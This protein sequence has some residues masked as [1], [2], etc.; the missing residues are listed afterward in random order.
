MASSTHRIRI[1]ANRNTVFQALSTETGLKGW[2]TANLDG[3]VAQGETATFHFPK[4]ETFRWKFTEVKPDSKIIW[5]C[6][7]GPGAAKGT[8][9]VFQLSDDGGQET[10][11]TCEHM[12]WPEGH[13][14][15]ATCNTLW[16]ILMGHLRDYAESRQPAPTFK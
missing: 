2:Y 4:D 16:G 7:D 5:E 13:E 10:V 8:K 15:L 12:G 9:A 3:P 11:L 14:A 6:E 1:H